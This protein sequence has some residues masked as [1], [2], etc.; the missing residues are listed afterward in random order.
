ML[1]EICKNTTQE[2]QINQ[3]IDLFTIEQ[4]NQTY[5]E[6]KITMQHVNL[7]F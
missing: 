1:F 5:S 3:P 6:L 7:I 4:C 2:V